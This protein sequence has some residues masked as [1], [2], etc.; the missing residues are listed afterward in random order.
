MHWQADTCRRERRRGGGGWTNRRWRKAERWR[1]AADGRARGGAGSR[2]AGPRGGA[3]RADAGAGARADGQPAGRELPRDLRA[4]RAAARR[5]GASRSSS[6]AATGTPGDS[7]RHPRWN[8]VARR[9]GA[10]RGA[11]CISTATSTWSRSGRAGRF[12]PFG[13]AVIDGRIYGRGACDMKGGLAAAIVAVEAFLALRPDVPGRDRD[14][15]DRRRGDRRLR[16]RRAPGASRGYFA[17]GRST[18]SS[19]PSR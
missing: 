15:G 18:T 11:A 1:E 2:G 9:E 19:S 14:L 8:L 3:G 7:D 10:R 13:G 4:D 6:C 12:D 17:P 5:P 16:R